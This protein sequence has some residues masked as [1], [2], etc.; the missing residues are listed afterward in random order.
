M[1]EPTGESSGSVSA[2]VDT[3]NSRFIGFL[4]L[5]IV[6]NS[7]HL[8]SLSH[9]SQRRHHEASQLVHVERLGVVSHL[10]PPSDPS[11]ESA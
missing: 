11:G 5:V 6:Q 3:H 1:S 10:A 2:H 9:C 4:V 7:R 8:G